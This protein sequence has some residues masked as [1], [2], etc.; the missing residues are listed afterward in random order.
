[1]STTR[2]SNRNRRVRTVSCK[3]SELEVPPEPL[4]LKSRR[5][6]AARATPPRYR[7]AILFPLRLHT[8]CVCLILRS[9]VARLVRQSGELLRPYAPHRETSD[10][11]RPEEVA[12]PCDH[13]RQPSVPRVPRRVHTQS[14]NH[15][16]HDR[17]AAPADCGS[18]R[19]VLRVPV[20]RP[21]VGP[22]GAAADAGARGAHGRRVRTHVQRRRDDLARHAR[23]VRA[24]GLPAPHVLVR[25]RRHGSTTRTRRKRG[26]PAS[27][28]GN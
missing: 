26:R 17:L 16:R 11:E 8:Q 3:N 21:S 9:A 27:A 28:P 6:N 2:V 7:Q 13:G 22:V 1:M 10:V 20:L 25:R 23:S 14:D 19:G 15:L 12:D 5:S 24:H 4:T 18:V